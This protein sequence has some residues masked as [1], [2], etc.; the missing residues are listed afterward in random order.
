[1]ERGIITLRVHI[2]CCGFFGFFSRRLIPL[3]LRPILSVAAYYCMDTIRL[4]LVFTGITDAMGVRYTRVY[5]LGGCTGFQQIM[6]LIY[7][8]NT[9]ARLFV[10]T[11]A[12]KVIEL[13]LC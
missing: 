12:M 2:G 10:K 11:L 1:M 3:F 8:R 5:S 7:A 6:M 13:R 9:H 4:G